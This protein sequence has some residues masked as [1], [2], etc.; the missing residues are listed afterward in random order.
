MD[1]SIIPAYHARLTALHIKLLEWVGAYVN[2]GRMNPFSE[3]ATPVKL[4]GEEIGTE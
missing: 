4:N 3:S 2:L 1:R